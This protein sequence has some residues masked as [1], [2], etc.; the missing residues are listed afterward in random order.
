LRISWAIVDDSSS[1]DACFSE[2]II[3]FSR[4][5]SRSTAGSKKRFLRVRRP[6]T[7]M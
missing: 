3:A 4:R 5:T 6:N 7:A 2:V 1:I